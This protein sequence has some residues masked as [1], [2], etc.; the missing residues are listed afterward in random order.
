[1]LLAD[2]LVHA[3]G[4]AA[5]CATH[6]LAWCLHPSRDPGSARSKVYASASPALAVRAAAYYRRKTGAPSPEPV[7]MAEYKHWA[8]AR[9]LEI[10]AAA[11][12][13]YVAA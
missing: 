6:N 4:D 12:E 8:A 2:Q 13:Q 10:L 7:T 5:N 9:S 1:M 11:R 3:D